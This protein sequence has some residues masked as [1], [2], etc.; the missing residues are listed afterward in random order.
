MLACPKCKATADIFYCD[1][2][3]GPSGKIKCSSCQ[4]EKDLEELLWVYDSEG[5]QKL[6][7]HFIFEL[8]ESMPDISVRDC[9]ELIER[10]LA[11]ITTYME[12]N[13]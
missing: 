3:M 13:L 7:I 9:R 11:P 2:G 6:R 4:Y 1:R 10:L 5:I 12:E 8:S